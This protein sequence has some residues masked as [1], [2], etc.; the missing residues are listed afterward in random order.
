MHVV[1]LNGPPGSGK[2]EVANTIQT[3]LG[4]D[5]VALR[6][7]AAP[8]DRIVRALYP[9]LSDADFEMYREDKKNEP[10]MGEDFT[11]RELYIYTS[12]KYVKPFLGKNY[13]AEQ[14]YLDVAHLIPRKPEVVVFSDSG[15]QLEYEHIYDRLLG[16]TGIQTHLVQVHREGCTFKG[17]SR[18]WVKPKYVV[19]ELHQYH[20]ESSL[21]DMPRLVA[22]MIDG[23]EL[24]TA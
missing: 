10:F 19:E 7:F 9:H 2:S 22:Q 5:K 23:L 14:A 20:N 24:V 15:F 16:H 8:L 11:L 17:D 4:D 13:F 6:K 18:E 1:F 21:D 12:E 3:L